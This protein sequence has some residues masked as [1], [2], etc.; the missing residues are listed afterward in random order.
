MRKQ[1]GR[2]LR[3][4]FCAIYD[5]TD[6]CLEAYDGADGGWVRTARDHEEMS[7]HAK[8]W[9]VGVLWTSVT[10]YMYYGDVEIR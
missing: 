7:H 10:S 9:S 2:N 4:Y 3:I 1:S 8:A 5:V 6:D